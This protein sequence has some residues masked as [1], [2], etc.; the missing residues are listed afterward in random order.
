MKRFFVFMIALF[1]SAAVYGQ[2]SRKGVIHV[3]GHPHELLTK[4]VRD[5]KAQ[6]PPAIV[7][8]SGD[9]ANINLDSIHCWTSAVTDPTLPTD[10]AVLLI[11]WTDGKINSYKEG[12]TDSILAWGYI[13]NQYTIY[14]DPTYGPDTTYVTKYTL[15]MIRAVANADCRFSVLLQNTSGTS[16]T[17]GG[18]GYN[19]FSDERIPI[20]AFDSASAKANPG[21]RFYYTDS[22]NCAVGQTAIP[23]DVEAQAEDAINRSTGTGENLMATGIIRHPFDADYGYPAYD[24]DYWGLAEY[25]DDYEWQSGWLNGYWSFYMR[26]GLSGNFSYASQ[27]ISGRVLQNHSVD[28]F[29]FQAGSASYGMSGDFTAPDCDCGCNTPATNANVN[30]SKRK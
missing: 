1:V 29:V 3:Q 13:W 24:Y 26:D 22:S 27:G 28:G 6:A 16:F 17:A 7:R 19:L 4:K 25:S 20:M 9:V 11:K 18:F 8:A 21:I 30:R 12:T 2:N 5:G 14:V 23:Y 15:D 10:T